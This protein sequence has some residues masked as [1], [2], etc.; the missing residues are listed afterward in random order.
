LLII[1]SSCN[2]RHWDWHRNRYWCDRNA[3]CDY[4]GVKISNPMSVRT[5]II[6]PT[7]PFLIILKMNLRLLYKVVSYKWIREWIE[8]AG[9]R[10]KV[11]LFVGVN[12][13]HVRSGNFRRGNSDLYWWSVCIKK[14]YNYLRSYS[15][16]DYNESSKTILIFES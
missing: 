7:I 12:V 11:L 5:F 16:K 9:W 4:H 2:W 15:Y 3:G 10:A 6:I 1:G 13:R 8:E 14:S